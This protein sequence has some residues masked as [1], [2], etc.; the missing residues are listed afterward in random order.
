VKEKIM[1]QIYGIYSFIH[2]KIIYVGQTIIGYEK[3]FKNHLKQSDNKSSKKIHKT[4]KKYGKE[5]FK[6]VLLLECDLGQLNEKEIEMIKQYDTYK[7]GCNLTIGG[8]T[9]S[10]YK[11]KQK[12]KE[13]IGKKLK[14]RWENDRESIIESLK[15]RPIRKQS[16]QELE[17]RSISLK[18]DNPMHN[19]SVRNKL[20]ETC[21][22]KYESGYTNPRAQRWIIKLKTNEIVEIVDLKNFC[23]ESGLKY[24]AVYSAWARKKPHKFILNI[25][26]VE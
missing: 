3:R 7:N 26:K 12:T 19:E 22:K 21:K 9:M 5:N 24:N 11:H 23:I 8:E 14:E 6:P 4:I 17:K 16:I 18:K 10:G 25:E 13:T 15:K 20:S 2:D 1:G